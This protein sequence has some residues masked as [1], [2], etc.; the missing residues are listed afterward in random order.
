[1]APLLRKL[2]ISVPDEQIADLKA[3]LASTRWPDQLEGA[4]PWAYGTDLKYI[5]VQ[6]DA[7]IG[8]HPSACTT[9]P[10]LHVGVQRHAVLELFY[11]ALSCRIQTPGKAEPHAG[12]P[13]A[14]AGR[15]LAE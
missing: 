6:A 4:A 7:G 2:T 8:L 9:L 13:C 15:V 1:M 5:Q 11:I 12:M 3:R 10:E 14:G